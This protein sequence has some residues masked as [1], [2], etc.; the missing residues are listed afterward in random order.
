MRRSASEILRNLEQRIARLER[1][2]SKST[3]QDKLRALKN[4][5]HLKVS[6]HIN[7]YPF[8]FDEET[9]FTTTAK[10]TFDDIDDLV[11]FL[12][13]EARGTRDGYEVLV[14]A[15][16]PSRKVTSLEIGVLY[17]LSTREDDGLVVHAFFEI[18]K[19]DKS[20][21]EELDVVISDLVM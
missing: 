17:K 14:D 4:Q 3:L 6:V 13:R 7:K 16:R 19:A 18:K 15:M 20:S 5:L 8:G 2:A 11:D 21:L 1:K 12:E 9:D 10:K